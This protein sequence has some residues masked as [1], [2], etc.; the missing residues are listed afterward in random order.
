MPKNIVVCSDGTGNTAIKGR[1]TNVFKLFE[2]VDLNGHRTAPH[3]TPQVAIYDDG[4][5][6]EDFKP[7]K[8]F[9]GATGF[10]L[11]RNVRQLYKELVRVYDPG[12]RI[13][14][15][16]FSRGAFTVRTLAGFISRC[17][18]LD[19][20]KFETAKALEG[21]VN[22]AYKTYRRY[23][24][25]ELARLFLGKPDTSMTVRFREKYC[26]AGPVPIAF[27]G[28]WDTVDSVG[29]P[30]HISDFINLVI[31][32]YKFP[33]DHLSEVVERAC[34]ALAVNEER[35]A[36]S[37]LLWRHDPRVEQV[38][39]AGAHSNVGGGYPKQGMSLVALDWMM[40]QA[41][42]SDLRILPT[43]RALYCD[44][45]NVDDKLY[46]PRA[47]LGAFYRWLP[48]DIT[49]LCKEREIPPRIHL[50]VLERVAHGTE[51]YA[52]GNLPPNAHV[53][54]TPT[55]DAAKDAAARRRA[56]N[57]QAVLHAAHGD[58]QPLLSKVRTPVRMGRIAYY[59][60][61][62]SCVAAILAACVP[63]GAGSRL[64]PWAW[65]K[66]AGTLVFNAAT[67]QFGPLMDSLKRL[68]TLPELA[69][70]IVGALL[71]SYIL[72]VMANARMSAVYSHFWHHV[73]PHLRTALKSAREEPEKSTF[74]QG[75]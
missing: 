62:V 63:E 23:Y 46:N 19:L 38:W 31:Y 20:A 48:R 12:D 8:M 35:D 9:A 60:Y 13:F 27:M 15:F 33:D 5:G 2:A 18:I 65:L 16:G 44:H 17:G 53:V 58:G 7:L 41:S 45:C 55:G 11:A 52:P 39:F 42:A 40:H 70:T 37:P 49:A 14:L 69:G 73:Q 61:V 30:F 34:H 26:L 72:I 29:T 57:V 66:N 32:R 56:A 25:T 59:V 64:N 21:G 67:L 75:A 3:L 24:R 10:G 4:V 43:D 50:S 22:R 6:T 47:G 54:I 51:D 1:G 36:F 28:V 74:A 71:L 68:A